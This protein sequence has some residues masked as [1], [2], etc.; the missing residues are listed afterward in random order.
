M[1]ILQRALGIFFF[2]ASEGL[3]NLYRSKRKASENSTQ[4][5]RKR[6]GEKK[7]TRTLVERESVRTIYLPRGEEDPLQQV[8]A[9]DRQS[10]NLQP[11]G[12]E[13]ASLHSR[14]AAPRTRASVECQQH[15]LHPLGTLYYSHRYPNNAVYVRF[16]VTLQIEMH[17]HKKLMK[18]YVL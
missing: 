9:C 13:E 8:H 18:T 5:E 15:C 14:C 6:E 11:R 1:H 3:L 2:N 4:K 10:R 16:R 17:T 12:Y 7:N